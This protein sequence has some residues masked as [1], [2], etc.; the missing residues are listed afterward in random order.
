MYD[1]FDMRDKC[2]I[3]VNKDYKISCSKGNIFKVLVFNQILV[4]LVPF[5]RTP[6]NMTH[7]TL[8]RSQL[9]LPCVTPINE[10]VN[11][12]LKI[13]FRIRAGIKLN[14]IGEQLHRNIG[15]CVDVLVWT[16]DGL[17]L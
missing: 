15:Y 11:C 16:F 13:M 7:T 10:L 4:S 3:V 5:L 6:V 17:I 9:Q 12:T 8:F 14:V 2:K 1:Y